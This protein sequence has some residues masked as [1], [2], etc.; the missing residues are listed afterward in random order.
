MNYPTP[1]TQEEGRTY[2][3]QERWANWIALGVTLLALFGGILIRDSVIL[4]T[5]FY[6]D[7][8]AGISARRPAGWLVD[9]GEDYVFRLSDPKARPFKTALQVTVLPV[10]PD[11]TGRNALDLLSLR[12]S[13]Q[14]SGYRVLSVR[15]SVNTARGPASAMR[16]AYVASEANPFLE[17]LPVVVRGVDVVFF[18]SNQAI[19]ASYQANLDRFD[20]EYFRFEQFVASL[21]F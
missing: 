4:E 21:R 8:S 1:P 10:G 5:V 19:I 14:L 16:Y 17:T 7:P 3:T 13:T 20:D 11:A 18:K 9:R 15:D 12:R 2:T 6:E